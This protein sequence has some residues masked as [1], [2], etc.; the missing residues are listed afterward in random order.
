M[1]LN[2]KRQ[3]KELKA[4]LKESMDSFNY[5]DKQQFEQTIQEGNL[6][7]IA[8][9]MGT[10]VCIVELYAI[11]QHA[12]E[13]VHFHHLTGITAFAMVKGVEKTSIQPK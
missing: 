10:S 5:T 2:M 6:Q 8:E 4:S 1:P 9:Y 12:D 7:P 13:L 11:N 3:E